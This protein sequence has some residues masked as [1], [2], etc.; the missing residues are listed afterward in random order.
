[1]PLYS[2]A[3]MIAS[4]NRAADVSIYRVSDEATLYNKMT[5]SVTLPL[6]TAPLQ[7]KKKT[8][9]G[10]DYLMKFVLKSNKVLF[11]VL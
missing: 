7:P 10:V 4:L 11:T 1:M 9:K 8:N 3:G 2:N 6:K 5:V